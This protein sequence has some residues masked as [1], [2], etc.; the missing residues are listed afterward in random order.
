ML[1]YSEDTDCVIAGCIHRRASILDF[2][3]LPELPPLSGRRG[4]F[5]VHVETF[6]YLP[7]HGVE[8]FIFHLD[9]NTGGKIPAQGLEAFS[10]HVMVAEQHCQR[11]IPVSAFHGAIP[12]TRTGG[13]RPELFRAAFLADGV[14]H[15][16]LLVA[17]RA[18][19]LFAGHRVLYHFILIII[20]AYLWKCIRLYQ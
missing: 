8:A 14:G 11:D 9:I 6:W 1:H 15:M 7:S 2:S 13:Y 17:W 10:T 5:P 18:M 12:A 4:L 3:T 20:Y 16:F 19:L